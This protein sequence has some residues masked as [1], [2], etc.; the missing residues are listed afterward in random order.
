MLILT[1]NPA[2]PIYARLLDSKKSWLTLPNPIRRSMV[3][4]DPKNQ[5]HHGVNDL[6]RTQNEGR[7]R[8]GIV[9]LLPNTKPFSFGGIIWQ[10]ESNGDSQDVWTYM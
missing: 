5:T 9:V 2:A 10:K 4:K 3:G 1:L 8:E 7:W 6:E